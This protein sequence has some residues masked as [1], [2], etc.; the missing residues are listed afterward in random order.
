MRWTQA[1]LI[2]A[3]EQHVDYRTMADLAAALTEEWQDVV[4][5][6][7]LANALGKG[8]PGYKFGGTTGRDLK[9]REY[10]ERMALV[11][12][13]SSASPPVELPPSET[14]PGRHGQRI[15]VIPDTQVK[16]GVPTDHLE[17]AARYIAEQKPDGVLMLGDHY[18]F[19]SLSSYMGKGRKGWEQH[20]VEADIAAGDV[21][22]DRL[23]GYR[24]TWRPTWE[25]LLLGNHE[26]RVTRAIDEDPHLSGTLSL[27]RLNFSGWTVHPFLKVVTLPGTDILASHFFTPPTSPRPIGG[28][29]HNLLNKVGKSCI[30]GHR[31]VLDSAVKYLP[32]GTQVRALIAGAFYDHVETYRQSNGEWRGL[33]VLNEVIGSTWDQCEVSLGYLRRKY[34]R[35]GET[36]E[37]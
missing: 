14:V 23:T 36:R 16:P 12:G 29:A 25:W 28:S 33:I 11:D 3:F 32:D 17:W 21:A 2:Y 24:S 35:K 19:P 8:Y 26:N 13:E 20:L 30:M 22:M 5:T 34:G 37:E 31:Q 6:Y 4:T 18:D 9:L 27:D 1:K 7:A 10:R 15:I